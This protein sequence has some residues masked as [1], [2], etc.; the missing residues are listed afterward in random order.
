MMFWSH[1][2]Q[3]AWS[4]KHPTLDRC[5]CWKD[6]TC[7]SIWQCW[8]PPD[9]PWSENHSRKTS[10]QIKCLSIYLLQSS[11][12][13]SFRNP[14]SYTKCRIH[15]TVHLIKQWIEIILHA[16]RPFLYVL[17]KI[18]GEKYRMEFSIQPT[19]DS[20]HRR[21]DTSLLRIIRWVW[22]HTGKG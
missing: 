14:N 2:L 9:F 8:D 17:L 22:P 13:P 7:C 3:K 1:S 6:C 5:V 15:C 10:N 20:I 12:Q 16:F 18:L 21:F 11:W 4:P 19:E